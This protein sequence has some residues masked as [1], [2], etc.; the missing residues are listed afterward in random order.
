MVFNEL[1]NNYK[2]RLSPDGLTIRDQ[3]INSLKDNFLDSFDE[4]MISRENVYYKRKNEDDY[5]NI[6]AQIYNLKKDNERVGLDDYKRVTFKDTMFRPESGDLIRYED[7]DWLVLNTNAIDFIKGCVIAQCNNTISINK[8]NTWY[9]IPTL[10][11]SQVQ[12]HSMGYD[13]HSKIVS[14]DNQVIARISN[15]KI[16]KDI[17]RNTVFKLGDYDWYNIIDINRV[18]EPGIIVLKF[19]WVPERP[20]EPSNIMNVLTGSDSIRVDQTQIYTAY[21]SGGGEFTFDVIPNDTPA[22]AY[23]FEVISGNTCEITAKESSYTIILRA[24]DI[25]T[26]EHYDKTINLFNLF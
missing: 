20:S 19:D 24:T 11:L 5:F 17:S 21:V 22:S 15:N 9:T 13:V 14:T 1:F 8:Y 23:E 3:Y 18:I 10:V 25:S 2:A 12:F 4:N 7:R 26:N 16:T 6:E